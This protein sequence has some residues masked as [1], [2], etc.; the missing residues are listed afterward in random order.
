MKA[1]ACFIRFVLISLLASCDAQSE[2]FKVVDVAIS[3]QE[4]ERFVSEQKEQL[5][6]VEGGEFLMG[7]NDGYDG[8]DL[9]YLQT[10][11][12]NNPLHKVELSSY[13]MS[14]FKVMNKHYQ[15]YLKSRGLPLRL[16]SISYRKD[17]AS[18]SAT[19]NLGANMD[20]YEANDYCAWLAEISGVPF[21]LPTEA[22]W[23]YAARS[24]GQFLHV[25]TDDG[26]YKITDDPVSEDGRYGP[27][28]IN[29]ST[30]W[31][32]K[33]YAAEKG[34]RLGTLT[35]LP[36][37]KFPPNPL[38]LYS[39]S[40]DG[41]EWVK[42]WYDPDYYKYSPHKDP[43]GPEGPVFK[44]ESTANQYAKVLRGVDIADPQWGA[45]TNMVRDYR[46]PDA[47]ML[48]INFDGSPMLFLSDKTARCVVNSSKPID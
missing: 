20:W 8:L 12:N 31:D 38:G 37:D 2:R 4:L 23:E 39:M 41:L 17:W 22:Q 43:Q 19:P 24:R 33:A 5:V 36:V 15:L 6:F 42:D 29:I 28:G 45:A 30:G 11:T 10:S 25:A 7:Y 21:A 35:P 3:V 14:Q 1:D 34:W 44:D 16:P 9:S 46:S 13:S 40:D 47:N 27:R 32:R 18:V 26:T 48:G